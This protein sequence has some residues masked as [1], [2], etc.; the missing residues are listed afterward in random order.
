MWLMFL[1]WKPLV[2]AVTMTRTMTTNQKEARNLIQSFL[3]LEVRLL[4]CPS[5]PSSSRATTATC[6]SVLVFV[7]LEEMVDPLPKDE[8]GC[9]Y[10]S[11]V[12]RACD[13][14]L[15]CY[16][17]LFL[18]LSLFLVACAM[19]GG[20]VSS[21]HFL[22]RFAVFTLCDLRYRVY[23]HRQREI[24]CGKKKK[25]PNRT[26]FRL[27]LLAVSWPADVCVMRCDATSEGTKT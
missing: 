15:R 23:L 27:V 16:S 10:T 5:L 7:C 12:G 8:P 3:F 2:R 1:V 25:R 26:L 17:C 9:H 24:L 6:V 20:S 22:L 14:L 4:V 19:A 18:R 21:S 11:L 13:D